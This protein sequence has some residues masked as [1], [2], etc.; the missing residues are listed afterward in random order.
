M[1][2]TQQSTAIV[3]AVIAALFYGF[4]VPFSKLMLS[5]ISVTMLSSSLYFGAGVGMLLFVL[6]QPSP[7]KQLHHINYHKKDLKYI[8]L[9]ILLDII[10]PILLMTG[11]LQTTASTASLLNNFEIIF[12]AIIAF[13]F[14]KERIGKH[15]WVAILF[16]V[17]AGV[18]LSMGDV[19]DIHFSSGTIFILLACLSWGLENNCTR[20]LSKGNP[21]HVVIIKGIGAGIGAFLVSVVIQDT[22][23]S[24]PYYILGMILGFFTF[25]LSLYFYIRAQRDLGAAR[26][27]AYYSI[28]PFVGSLFSFVILGEKLTIFFGIAFVVMAFGSYLA[29]IENR[30]TKQ[31]IMDEVDS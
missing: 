10:A 26:T 31:S 28:A 4:S 17:G 16:I 5:Q 7:R 12:T 14:F 22:F 20:M 29:L 24:I 13:A 15:M 30:Q 27:S 1:Y 11:L 9:M 6:L 2:K 23:A 8:I 21:I 18:L 25:G 3:S 19:K